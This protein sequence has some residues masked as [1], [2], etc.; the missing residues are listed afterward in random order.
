MPRTTAGALPPGSK[1]RYDAVLRKRSLALR[2]DLHRHPEL[3]FEE[4]RTAE[5]LE[6]ELALLGLAEIRRVGGHRGS[7]RDPG[8]RPGGAHGGSARRHR[9]TADPRGDRGSYASEEP[10]IMH[11]RGHDV[12][13]AWTVGAAHLLAREPA[14][15]DV[16]VLLQPAEETG[17]GAAAVLESGAL[18]G[19]GAIFGAHVDRL[20][21]GGG[22]CAGRAAHGGGRRVPGGVGG[23]GSASALG[24]TRQLTQSWGRRRW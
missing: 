24:P 7:R 14:A 20:P 23:T 9:R 2:H 17:R 19:V 21:G 8:A 18:D 12:H 11:A 1:R 13:A 6:H 5:R 15:G 22:G 4:H 16:L 10:G 3:A